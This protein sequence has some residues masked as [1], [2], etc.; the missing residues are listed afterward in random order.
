MM[1]STTIEWTETSWNPVTGCSKVSPGCLHCYAERMAKR[2]RAMGQL[3][4]RDRLAEVAPALVWPRNVWMGVTVE[5]NEH[6]GRAERLR[7]V[8]SAVRFLSI[9]PLLGQ[10]PALNLDG[11]DWVI[12]GGESGPG[13]RPMHE[14]W[15]L[16]IRDACL[17][18]A[19]PFFF[20][21][22]GGTRKKA[23][24][25]ELESRKWSEMPC[26]PVGV[27]RLRHPADGRCAAAGDAVIRSPTK[28]VRGLE[29][30]S[31]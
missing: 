31:S 29:W 10:L 18:R 3:N 26:R 12:V 23:A 19:A 9:E 4:Y 11:I 30:N 17:D 14:N 15:V 20:K 21:Q 2:L 7:E 25:R 1:S 6:L 27:A 22:W 8:P 5:D 24:G 28:R 13:A 16:E